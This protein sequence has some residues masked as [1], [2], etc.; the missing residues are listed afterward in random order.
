VLLDEGMLFVK[1]SLKN[2][3]EGMERKDCRWRL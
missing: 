3:E 1:W 2:E